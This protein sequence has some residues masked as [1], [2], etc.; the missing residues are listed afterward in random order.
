VVD[1]LFRS[2]KIA[3]LTGVPFGFFMGLPVFL[4]VWPFGGL[5]VG[6]WLGFAVWIG[7]GV[8]FGVPMALF[9]ELFRLLVKPKTREFEN[10][11][12]QLQ[13][14]ANH[15]AGWEGRGGWLTLTDS[16]L[17]FRAHDFNFQRHPLDIRLDEIDDARLAYSFKVLPTG[18]SCDQNQWRGGVLCARPA[19]IVGEVDRGTS[20]RIEAVEIWGVDAMRNHLRR[21]ALPPTLV[22]W[23]LIIVLLLAGTLLSGCATTR[24]PLT[25]DWFEGRTLADVSRRLEDRGFSVTRVTVVD[26]DDKEIEQLIARHENYNPTDLIVRTVL[27][28]AV[29][30]RSDDRVG[31]VRFSFH[32]VGP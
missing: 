28:I 16:H 15:F 29:T 3:A 9:F 10:E 18:L 13:I 4:V 20:R 5:E 32:Y 31:E 30:P 12:V 14:P 1:A 11:T 8:L 19:Q 25:L 27:I 6:L 26:E 23:A 21:F 24:Q 2:L 22:K 17:S 7:S